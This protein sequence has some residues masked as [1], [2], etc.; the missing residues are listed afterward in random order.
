M[1]VL[2]VVYELLTAVAI[3]CE[4][5]IQSDLRPCLFLYSNLS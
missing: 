1:A 2:T 5:Q 3:K 4:V